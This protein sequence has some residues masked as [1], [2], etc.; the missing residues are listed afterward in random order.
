MKLGELL[1]RAKIG[2]EEFRN[3]ENINSIV[4][5]F[6]E[7]SDSYKTSKIIKIIAAKLTE[8]KCVENSIVI[9]RLKKASQKL[10]MLEEKI[11]IDNISR[12]YA[13]MKLD[14]LNEDFNIIATE[15]ESK[16]V[17]RSLDKENLAHALALMEFEINNLKI[18]AR[19]NENYKHKNLPETLKPFFKK[20]YKLITETI[21]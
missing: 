18:A 14:S 19:V 16:K 3:K 15:L 8:S 13:R 10:E 7:D 20:E 12:S 4:E 1:E 5:T 21:G 2:Q 17:L 6:D 9:K 11:S